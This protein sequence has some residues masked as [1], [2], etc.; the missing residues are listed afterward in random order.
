[1]RPPER[2]GGVPG[3]I[4][5]LPP[6]IIPVIPCIPAGPSAQLA[7][8]SDTSFLS[9]PIQRSST[10][11]PPST[12]K[13]APERQETKRFQIVGPFEHHFPEGADECDFDHEG[14][15]DPMVAEV[16]DQ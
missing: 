16:K 7:S 13:S 4:S 2:K 9:R 8:A 5:A 11:S 3:I 10:K 14:H 15:R 1:M 12:S 6:G